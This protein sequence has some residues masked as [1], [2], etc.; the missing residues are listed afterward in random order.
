[1]DVSLGL[2]CRCSQCSSC[3][4]FLPHGPL[5]IRA[6]N[7]FNN[8]RPFTDFGEMKFDLVIT[9]F[10]SRLVI[11]VTL[12]FSS[13]VSPTDFILLNQGKDLVKEHV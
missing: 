11:R 3:N 7:K 6:E 8:H 10:N 12:V 4:P 9:K 1:M 2:Q 13:A 5:L